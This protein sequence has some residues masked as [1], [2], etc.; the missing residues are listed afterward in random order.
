MR[1]GE[2]IMKYKLSTTLLFSILLSLCAN[3]GMT[4]SKS[5][6][7]RR[8]HADIIA[9]LSVSN[10]EKIILSAGFDGVM[11]GWQIEDNNVITKAGTTL[12]INKQNLFLNYKLSGEKNLVP[13]ISQGVMKLFSLSDVSMGTEQI[14]KLDFQS[15]VTSVAISQSGNLTAVGYAAGVI[16]IFDNLTGKASIAFQRHRYAVTSMAFSR[17]ENILVSGDDDGKI[18]TTNLATGKEDAAIL[19]GTSAIVN[20]YMMSDGKTV[21]AG[22]QDNVL[23]IWDMDSKKEIKSIRAQ[24]WNSNMLSVSPDETILSYLANDTLIQ[25]VETK[26]YQKINSLASQNS[27]SAL[28]FSP[29]GK[30]F[31]AANTN[32]GITVW[33]I[34][35]LDTKPI[36][37]I[38]PELI[39][40]SPLVT[41]DVRGMKVAEIR[42]T[43]AVEFSGIVGSM[44]TIDSVTVNG[45]RAL[46]SAMTKDEMKQRGF[47]H[48][49]GIKFS[50]KDTL[51][52]GQ[53]KILI[54]VYSNRLLSIAENISISL[55]KN[56]EA[57]KPEQPQFQTH[58][59][60]VGVSQY[61]E[62]A[63]NLNYAAED[64]KLFYRILSDPRMG[65]ISRNN[66]KLLIDDEATRE[67]ILDELEARMKTTAENDVVFIYF[68]T[69]GFSE[70]GEVYYMAYNTNPS[71]LRL[72][73]VRS[74][75]LVDVI[76]KYGKNRKVIMFF[77]ACNSG[78]TGQ[79]L[80]TRGA[81]TADDINAFYSEIAKEKEFF[82]TISATDNGEFSREGKEWGDGHGVFT[83]YLA[84]GI[85]GGANTDY[86][87]YVTLNEL[88]SFVLKNVRQD[89]QGKQNPKLHYK[90]SANFPL[91]VPIAI[92]SK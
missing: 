73:G 58:A 57:P 32:G 75:D 63:W 52:Y 21:V 55:E 48:R 35:G 9:S 36:K 1:L 53:Y 43:T 92:V 50:F 11:K 81:L 4:L 2:V 29:Q 40:T 16:H 33:R 20:L 66:V 61:K 6:G 62:S 5:F 28:T 47:E 3:A 80:A 22:S 13:F 77:D 15:S 26:E 84:M 91:N 19:R 76:Q 69:H 83:Y 41:K 37:V 44:S 25:F 68:A 27:I 12:N 89:T 71:K 90:Q 7:I 14:L 70:D 24:M 39:I 8:A 59:F 79:K 34:S 42:N 18:W 56:V 86:D 54:N 45:K 51:A 85:K 87:Q 88:Y 23:R 72:S 67:T 78:G 31:C 10:N 65:A 74:Q 64:A 82:V 49:N 38:P 17:D 46:L 60:I 30:I